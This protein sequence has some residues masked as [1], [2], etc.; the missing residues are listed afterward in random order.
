MATLALFVA[1]GGTSAFAASQLGKNSIGTKQ[2]KAKSVTTAKIK[3]NAVT[4]KKIADNAVTGQKINLATLGTVP[5]AAHATSAD[6]ATTAERATTA[7]TAAN[8]DSATTVDGQSI[9]SFAVSLAENG[10]SATPLAFGG[11][12]L[13]AS[14]NAPKPTLVATRTASA[15]AA[16]QFF[17]FQTDSAKGF[18]GEQSNFSTVAIE[19]GT[20]G[21]GTFEVY[22]SDG[23]VTTVDYAYRANTFSGAPG[24][25][26]YGKAI[27][28]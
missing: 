23:V 16:A 2:L 22:F 12:T 28:G 21:A 25:R 4:E 3:P 14:C 13:T 24:C 20:F 9:A 6:G 10:P 5:S 18:A 19:S 27:T 8:A 7:G 11:I 1:L 15:S 17:G 26:V